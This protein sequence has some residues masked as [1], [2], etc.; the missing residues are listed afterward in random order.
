[1]SSILEALRELEGDRPPAIRRELPPPE[2]PPS[3][4]RRAT[5]AMIPILGGLAV[6]IV[7]FGIYAWGPRV[8]TPP[9][10]VAPAA[11]APAPATPAAEAQP[12]ERPNWLDTADAPR[13]KVGRTATAAPTP[14]PERAVAADRPA[15]APPAKPA[16]DAVAAAAPRDEAPAERADSGSGASSGGQVAVEKIAY[17]ENA[18]ER[19][20]TMRFKGRRVTLRQRESIDGIEVQLIMPNGVYVQRGTE[21]YLL[22]LSR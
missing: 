2:A 18:A 19:V 5:G 16:S 12:A 15:A 14:A 22:P 20:V 17:S 7:A 6:G 1:V 11:V 9:T 3:V 4:A 10:A 8:A 13:A 21:T